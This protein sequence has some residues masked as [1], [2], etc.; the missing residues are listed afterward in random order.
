MFCRRLSSIVLKKL[1]R[2]GGDEARVRNRL[3]HILS[4]INP[5]LEFSISSVRTHGSGS[6]P[7]IYEVILDDAD[8]ADTLRKSFAKFTRKK[9]PVACP[10]ELDEVAVYNSVTLATRV[11]ISILRVRFGFLRVCFDARLV[12][13]FKSFSFFGLVSVF[14]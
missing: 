5:D 8:A 7:P 11:R 2:I 3:G 10:P 9:N 6:G 14:T 4:K 1:G 12:C 13:I